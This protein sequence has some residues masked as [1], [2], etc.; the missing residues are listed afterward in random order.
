MDEL[1]SLE[2]ER[3]SPSAEIDQEQLPGGLGNWTAHWQLGCIK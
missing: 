2:A 1:I 3:V